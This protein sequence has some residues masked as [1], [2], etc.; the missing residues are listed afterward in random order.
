M[1]ADVREHLEY[2][3]KGE[4][5]IRSTIR[6]FEGTRRQV[7]VDIIK[8]HV[9]RVPPECPDMRLHLLPVP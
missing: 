6:M 4:R 7:W 9:D 2:R 5:Q 8:A 3:C 1:C